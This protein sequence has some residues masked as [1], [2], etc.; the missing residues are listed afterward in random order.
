[1]G[2]FGA[3][4]PVL[5][6]GVIGG[7]GLST[8]GGGNPYFGGGSLSTSPYGGPY[9]LSTVPYTGG[10]VPPYSQPYYNLGNLSSSRLDPYS[11]YLQGL[12][13]VTASTGQYQKDIQQARITRYKANDAAIENARRIIQHEAWLENHRY[14]S[15]QAVLDRQLAADLASARREAPR[16]D[17]WSGKA[18]NDLLRSVVSSKT[19]L[20]RGPSLSLEDDTLKHINLSTKATSCNAGMLRDNGKLTWPVGLMEDSLQAPRERLSRK[21]E[22][23]VDSI[24]NGKNP[25]ATK[26]KE[27]SEDFTTIQKKLNDET[28]N[29]IPVSDYLAAKRYLAKL[30]DAITALRDPNAKK[31]FDQHLERQGPHRPRTGQ[32]HAAGRPVVQQ[33]RAGRRGGL[34]PAS[35][36]PS[37]PSRPASAAS[38][39]IA[40]A[41]RMGHP[42]RI[43]SVSGPPRVLVVG[44]GLAG[45]AAAAAL[46]PRGCSV[47]LLEARH[48]PGGRA[49]S[50][51][52]PASG[53]LLD[54]CQHV[55]MGCCTNLAHFFAQL[56]LAHLFSPLPVLHF[57]TPDGPVQP[58]RGR[59]PPCPVPPGAV[60][61]PRPLPLL[62]RQG[63]HRLRPGPPLALPPGGRPALRRLARRPRADATRHRALLGR[64]PGQRPQRGSWPRRPALRPQGLRGRL[65]LASARLRGRGAHRA[66]RPALRPGAASV[67]AAPRSAAAPRVR[68]A[69]PAPG[70]R[71]NP[72]C[73]AA[74]AANGWRRTSSFWRCRSGA[75]WTCCRRRWLARRSSTACGK[76]EPSPITS[77]HLWHDRPVTALPH[78]VLVGCLGQWVFRR[79]ETAP[80]EHYCQV[81]V[82]AAR[83]LRG[84]GHDEVACRIEQELRSVFPEARAARLLRSRVVT[85]HAATF[86]AVP[87]VDALRPPQ[88]TP[89]PGLFLAGDWT[90]TGWP[91]TMEGAVRSGRFAA[92]ALLGQRGRIVRPGLPA[93]GW[94]PTQRPIG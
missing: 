48:R 90:R 49:G 81:V 45:L 18:L 30:K 29:D 78:A 28:Y 64:R 79:G 94:H 70:T 6:G 47:V 66:P 12:A 5:G 38:A 22:E 82:S 25:S 20:A 9:G 59:P 51:S 13:A 80:G 2:G 67:A 56:G 76:L 72:R 65:P 7:Y 86:S 54:A 15:T 42:G 44:A 91:A 26:L 19:S 57:V 88:A 1:M 40:G 68:R 73:R 55:S 63:P 53:Q 31:F 50:F 24:K 21:L 23:A 33:R 3:G 77:V 27:I 36:S 92:E 39:D 32:L 46:A 87:G 83:S 93:P 41:G 10:Y 4:G 58:L 84:L 60:V 34:H 37:A 52:D 69:D 75:C 14:L 16:S 17:I 8:V 35:T 74:R 62:G 61:R 11:G 71:T 43:G 89:W 85:E